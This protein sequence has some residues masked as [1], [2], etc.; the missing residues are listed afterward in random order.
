MKKLLFLLLLSSASLVAQ[1]TINYKGENINSLDAQG[2]KVGLWKVYSDH[3]NVLITIDYAN[4]GKINFYKDSTLIATYH[5]ENLEIYKDSKTIKAKFFEKEN[6]TQ[7]LVGEDGKELD[8]EIIKYYS[9]AAE[10]YPMFYGGKDKLFA[11]IGSNFKKSKKDEG[12]I[13]VKFV[14]DP[15]GYVKDIT[16]AEST[17]PELNDEAI[18]VI[19]TLPRWQPG[20]QRARFV[21]VSYTVPI[22]IQKN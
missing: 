20:F 16:I 3:N 7:T 9:Q 8:P 18:R 22:V 12:K 5:K 2:N 1:S 6:K 21:N 19:K 15:N 11:Y 4:G 17:I 13:K 14:I 10:S